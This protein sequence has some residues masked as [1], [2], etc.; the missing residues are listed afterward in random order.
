MSD[1]TNLNGHI[2]PIAPAEVIDDVPPDSARFDTAAALLRLLV[3]GALVGM[4]ELRTR[5]ERW[6]EA[7]QASAQTVHQTTRRTTRNDDAT[8][9]LRR[10]AL[11]AR[12]DAVET[13]TR[14]RRGFAT[15][16]AR[17]S[18]FSRL[19]GEAN[20][21]YTTLG[22]DWHRTPFDPLR[23]RLDEMRFR[24]ME[25]VDRWADRGWA[26]EQQGRRMAQQAVAG[27]IDEL[28]DYMAQNPEVRHLIEEQG[29]GMAETAVDEVRE[30]TASADMWI[31]R[32]AH[33]LLH[34]PVS[35]PSRNQRMAPRRQRQ[36]PRRMRPLRLWT[37]PIPPRGHHDE[38]GRP[39]RRGRPGEYPMDTAALQYPHA[40]FISRAI[41]FVLDI[42]VMSVAL[43]AAIALVQSLL[44]FFTLY[45][46]V[47]QRVAQSTP[48]RDIVIAVCA[49][50]G[51]GIAIGYPV[52]FWVLLGQ[53]PGKLLM[54]VRIARIN[55]QPLTIRRALLR[56]VG[57]WLSAIPLGLGFFWVLVDDRRQC[58]H[59]KLAARM[60]SM[61]RG[62]PSRGS[63]LATSS[64]PRQRGR[65]ALRLS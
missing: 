20:I 18:R 37:R 1:E 8:N 33:N 23:V 54:G 25:T 26:E 56:Y 47:G 48:F 65:V 32:I 17:F 60:S 52:G 64:S 41:A 58:W 2:R 5:L 50:I 44:G 21:F 10:A 49:L 63:P 36:P 57:Y 27:V 16:A 15:M 40:G 11:Y 35:G 28:L 45:G 43:L 34:R 24:A 22:S 62:L 51:V 59:D 38:P 4:D 55:G 42:V 12:R 46:L 13:E 30:R 7:T 53:T 39:G 9:H 19:S 31:E 61:T 3:G 6:Q 14:M 29:M